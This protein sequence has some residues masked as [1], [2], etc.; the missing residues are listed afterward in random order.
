MISFFK[1]KIKQFL[2]YF[3]KWVFR[4]LIHK[5]F[6]IIS[7]DCWGAEIYRWMK[8]PYNT[9]FVGLML[10]APCYIKLIQN[11]NHYLSQPLTFRKDSIYS[12]MNS[13]RETRNYY[14]IGQLDDIEIHFLHYESKDD[15][16]D[17]W[18]RRLKRMNNDR[19]FIKFDGEKDLANTELINR[20]LKTTH[21]NKL[22]F[23]KGN[24]KNDFS[25]IENT[26]QIPEKHYVY[27]GA[28][29]FKKSLIY[30]NI[31]EWLNNKRLIHNSFKQRIITSI[32]QITLRR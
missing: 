15:A 28:A 1:R 20:F 9:P 11:L 6:T 32:L 18:N 7:N 5:D 25:K 17:K 31:F 24:T 16:L 23:L 2:A 21:N 12:E 4:F 14:P 19:L 22:C 26:V 10:M 8:K 30:F 3:N 13:F 27:D 29:L